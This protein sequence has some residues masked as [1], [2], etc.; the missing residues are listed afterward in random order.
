[1]DTVYKQKS[2][3]VS[4][5]IFETMSCLKTPQGTFSLGLLVQVSRP[6]LC[7]VLRSIIPQRL[8]SVINNPTRWN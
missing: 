5:E 4:D 1:M 8:M 6:V 7:P 2:T 3:I